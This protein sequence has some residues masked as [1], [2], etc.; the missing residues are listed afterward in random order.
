MSPITVLEVTKIPL[1]FL[2]SLIF[3]AG[4]SI[5]ESM[6]AVLSRELLDNLEK[7]RKCEI[8]GT[9]LCKKFCRISV[10]SPGAT[11]PSTCQ[12]HLKGSSCIHV[13]D[14]TYVCDEEKGN[15][16]VTALPQAASSK[17]HSL[18]KKCFFRD[19]THFFSN[20]QHKCIMKKQ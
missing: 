6:C 7:K 5:K 15:T 10:C 13:C 1:C 8:H 4:C 14:C 19:F 18:K 16:K 20:E 11:L 17:V 3:F 2:Q 9:C 12:H